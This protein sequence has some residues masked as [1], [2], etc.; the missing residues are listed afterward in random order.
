MGDCIHYV[1]KD[2]YELYTCVIVVAM[3]VLGIPTCIR[4]MEFLLMYKFCRKWDEDEN[5]WVGGTTICES[6]T[7]C[8]TPKKKT[9]ATVYEEADMDL[10]EYLEDQNEES[11]RVKQKPKSS[12]K[13]P[14]K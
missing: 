3:I 7:N 2:Y 10:D 5:A 4:T 14:K 13:K 6:M 12:L 11:V 9:E 1:R 8:C